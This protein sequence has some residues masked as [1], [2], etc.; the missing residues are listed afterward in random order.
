MKL[1]DIGITDDMLKAKLSTDSIKKI[2][3]VFED[4]DLNMFLLMRTK[5]EFINRDYVSIINRSR[6][7]GR[8]SDL[9]SES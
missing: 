4:I 6:P 9:G 2:K 3:K 1:S 7:I 8:T 5:R